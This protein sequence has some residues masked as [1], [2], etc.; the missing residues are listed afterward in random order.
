MVK[1]DGVWYHVDVTSDDPVPD[2]GDKIIDT[3]FLR[4]DEFMNESHTW[5]DGIWPEAPQDYSVAEQET[6]EPAESE[7]EE[8]GDSANGEKSKEETAG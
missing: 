4:S 2:Q 5:K 1:L 3:Y 8:K 6:K 7:K